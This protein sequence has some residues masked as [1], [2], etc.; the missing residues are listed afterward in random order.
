VAIGST[1]LWHGQIC[2]NLYLL[3]VL[4]LDPLNAS[5]K[6]C[7]PS[8]LGGYC[9]IATVSVS[10]FFERNIRSETIGYKP[11]LPDLPPF[12]GKV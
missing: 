1:H 10:W 4:G 5:M 11:G 9:L 6:L 7:W 12:L 3:E 8:L 2:A